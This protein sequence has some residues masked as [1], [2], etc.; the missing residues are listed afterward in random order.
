MMEARAA[1]AA[2]SELQGPLEFVGVRWDKKRRKWRTQINHNGKRQNVGYFD[3]E[4]EAARAVDTAARKLRGKDAHGGREPG[5][6][7]MRL[8]FPSKREVARAKALGMPAAKGSAV[9][10]R[11]I[12]KLVSRVLQCEFPK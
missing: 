1:A 11:R 10:I 5:G 4:C 7:W 12:V 8:S 6:G 2:A 3:D 9:G